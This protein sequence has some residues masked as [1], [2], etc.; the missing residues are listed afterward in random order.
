MKGRIQGRPAKWI[1][2]GLVVA[3][4]IASH[5]LNGGSAEAATTA[6]QPHAAVRILAAQDAPNAAS[7]VLA[8]FTSQQ[9]PT[10]FKFS[11]NARTLTIGAIALEMTCTSGAQFVLEDAF[12]PVHISPNGRLHATT[13][14]PPTA[15]SSGATYSGSDSLTAR[16]NH[17]HTD[18][19]GT[20]DLQVNY[21]FTN[22]MSDQC[23]SGP[24]RFTATH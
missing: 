7:V 22:G 18:V 24:V 21:S 11:G 23:D 19:S 5:A 14:I 1:R 10:F 16:L 12:G 20:W 6:P 17:R 3:A 9:Y 8:G 4:L 13:S 2:V 15:G